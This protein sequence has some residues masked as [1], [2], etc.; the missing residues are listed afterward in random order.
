MQVKIEIG[1]KSW[2][3]VSAYGSES[4]RNGEKKEFLG[5]IFKKLQGGRERMCDR[6]GKSEYKVRKK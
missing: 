1:K 6:N 2:I 5:I 4:K 3:K